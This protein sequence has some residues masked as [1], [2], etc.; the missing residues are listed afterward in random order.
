MCNSAI[1]IE[2]GARYTP[3]FLGGLVLQDGTKTNVVISRK[4]GNMLGPSV[5]V[6]N[7]TYNCIWKIPSG[8]N[9]KSFGVQPLELTPA[10]P[11]KLYMVLDLTTGQITH[12][13]AIDNN[14]KRGK[15]RW[16]AVECQTRFSDEKY[17]TTHMAFVLVEAGAYDIGREGLKDN[18]RHEVNVSDYYIGVF[19]VTKAQYELISQGGIRTPRKNISMQ[20]CVVDYRSL[21][22]TGTSPRANSWLGRLN[23]KI[24]SDDIAFDLPTESMWEIACRAGCPIGAWTSGAWIHQKEDKKRYLDVGK[25]R[26]LVKSQSEEDTQSTDDGYGNKNGYRVV[27]TK[28]S[29]SWEIHDMLGNASELCRDTYAKKTLEVLKN[30]DG[31]SPNCAPFSS[32]VVVRGGQYNSD[33]QSASSSYRKSVPVSSSNRFGFRLVGIC[34]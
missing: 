27:G 1:G 17:K 2:E 10:N 26:Y 21:R 14:Y 9:P 3:R 11:H 6:S 32:F 8:K 33:E 34:K 29:N 19:E 20:P 25:K 18:P 16:D 30:A 23:A 13:E 28:P 31:M 5:I 24:K 4:N 22:G 15:D 7:G 12:E